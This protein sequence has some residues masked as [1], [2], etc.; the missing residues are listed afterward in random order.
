MKYST[1][2]LN[3]QDLSGLRSGYH[4]SGFLM[5]T[6]VDTV[7]R[8]VVALDRGSESGCIT[9]EIYEGIKKAKMKKRRTAPHDRTDRQRRRS[10]RN[11]HY[12]GMMHDSSMTMLVIRTAHQREGVRLVSNDAR[13]HLLLTEER[14]VLVKWREEERQ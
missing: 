9:Q 12:Q 5:Q 10:R 11:S 3:P 14:E 13:R 2:S 1:C 6:N 4:G 7:L 8:R